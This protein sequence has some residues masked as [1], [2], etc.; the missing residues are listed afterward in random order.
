M[1]LDAYTHL[2]PPAYFERMQQHV[3]NKGAI[4]RW[5]NLPTLWDVE[6]RLRMI[7]SFGDYQQVLANSMP[8]VEYI[9]GPDLS[10]EL[11][12]IANDGFAELVAKY[13]DH[14][15]AF[16]ASLPMNNPE[17]AVAE[18][19]RAIG[20]LGA[21][22]VQIFTNVNGRPL[23]E[24][25]FYPIFERMAHHDLPIWLHPSRGPDFV[26]YKSEKKS[27]YEIWWTFGWPY[28]T[29]AA[30]SHI[31]FSKILERLPTLKI[32]THHMG[33]MIPFFEG[34]VG[35]GW[36]QLGS[37]TNDED[38]EGLL[39]S[40]KKRPID[41][42]R[43]FYAD[44]ALFGSLSGTKCGLDFFPVEQIVFASDCPFDPEGGYQFIR[45]TL[46]VLDALDLT[47]EQREK[48]M[49]GNLRRMM[50]LS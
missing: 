20:D 8:A 21:K 17:A 43:M 7:D 41:Y 49:G 10:P 30:M 42:F 32:I 2:F 25:E 26:D 48:I 15:P 11:S 34:R 29:S 44:T 27:K 35:P 18:I 5:L 22:G 12:R 23:D 39:K 24:E 36:D 38:Y 47:P 28:E 31:V 3:A 19:D 45:E 37:R 40:L 46:R 50:K 16:I 1:R 13:P 33:A 9:V 6:A 14:F 4:K